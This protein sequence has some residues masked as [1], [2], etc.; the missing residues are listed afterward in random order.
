[1]ERINAAVEKY[2]EKIFEVERFLWKHPQT[3]YREFLCSSYLEE[4]FEDLGY[5]KNVVILTQP[6]EFVKSKN[7]TTLVL[8]GDFPGG[9]L[10]KTLSSQCRGPRFHS[11][12]GN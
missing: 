7:K 6:R 1:M 4:I 10:A 5:N 8:V 2:R 12:S 11:W 3:G 9:L